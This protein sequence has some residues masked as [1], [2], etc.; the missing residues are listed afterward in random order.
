MDMCF[1]PSKQWH[2]EAAQAIR[3]K[4][5]TSMTLRRIWRTGFPALSICDLHTTAC[6]REMV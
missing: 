2:M 6:H 1:Y 4:L 5:I 3:G